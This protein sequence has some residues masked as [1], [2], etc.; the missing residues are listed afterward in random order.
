MV[1]GALDPVPTVQ[2]KLDDLLVVL[3]KTDP[4]SYRHWIFKYL[5]TLKIRLIVRMVDKGF[6]NQA[7]AV[8]QNHLL[9]KTDGFLTGGEPDKNDWISDTELQK[10]IYWPLHDMTVLLNIIP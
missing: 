1:Y 3:H 4:H 9:T 10:K 8:I 6:Y 2:D 7:V 5:L